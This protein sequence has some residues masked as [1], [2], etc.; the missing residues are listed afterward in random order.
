MLYSEIKERENRFIIALKIVF[1]F[2][3]LIVIF[4]YSF[5]IFNHNVNNFVLLVLLIPIYVYYI[6]YLIY[7]GFKRT[8]ID[9]TTKAF[10]R[11]E[12]ISKISKVKDKKN[13]TVILLRLDNIVDINERYGISNSDQLLKSLTQKIDE[14]LKSY[15]FKN[16]PIGRF[17]G[18]N[19]LFLIKHP[20][21]E[22][23]HLLTI[24]SKELKNKGINNI[25]VKIVFSLIE[26]DYD[27]NVKNTIEQ[28]FILLAK[29]K[30]SDLEVPNI[31]PDIFEQ[32]VEDALKNNQIFFK[33]QPSIN[34]E[35]KKIEILE[36]LT[37]IYS[38]ENGSLS[39]GQI[40]RIVNY[41]GSE[42][43]FDEKIFSLFLDEISPLLDKN[44]LFSI[45]ISPVSLRN[46]SFK[47][48]LLNLFRQKKI[49][50]NHFILEISE[51]NSYEDM[52]RFREIIVSYKKEGFKI[53]LSNFGGNNCSL[54]YIKHLPIDM[55]KF[56]IEFTKKIEDERQGKI[57][58]IYLELVKTLHVKSMIK[59][60][61]KELLFEK[62][63]A[64]KPDFIQG[65]FISK[66]KN[67]E[68]I[69]GELE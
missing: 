43:E 57:L 25:E 14:F 33:Y 19:F 66:P 26:A 9:F 62:I 36:V 67:L 1:P 41:A 37:K 64:F 24:F 44:I 11:K 52:N 40:E 4:F 39:K 20:K 2:F 17:G 38:K 49:N 10:I 46:N 6:F 32:I 5:T 54:E 60:A 13:N 48:Y 18:G 35:T 27:E 58:E 34:V 23:T 8:L 16:I 42:K 21:K 55:V 28:L 65:F 3:L 69:I 53:A 68:Q 56:D 59:F 15:H 50:P 45:D 31:K 51:I 30:K 12:I 7:N 63:K 22:L 61:D 47:I 29:N